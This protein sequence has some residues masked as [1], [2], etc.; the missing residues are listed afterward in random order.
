MAS[1]RFAVPAKQLEVMPNVVAFLCSD[2][3]NYVTSST[4]NVEGGLLPY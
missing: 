1:E 3:A 2:D 4:M